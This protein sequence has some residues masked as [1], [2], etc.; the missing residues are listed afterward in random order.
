[1]FEVG[2]IE[3]SIELL[4]ERL[5]VAHIDWQVPNGQLL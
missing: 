1:V 3:K 4:F 5:W 2:T